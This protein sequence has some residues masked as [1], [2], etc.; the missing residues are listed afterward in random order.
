MSDGKSLHLLWQMG[1]TVLH[2]AAWR[3]YLDCCKYF[4]ENGALVH[5]TNDVRGML[6]KLDPTNCHAQDNTTP[7]H[8]AAVGGHKEVSKYLID[9][10]ADVNATDSV[11]TCHMSI[12]CT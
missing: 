10:G 6:L 7:L 9:N 12:Q 11:I 5:S 8:C 3:G 4:V 2:I 1:S